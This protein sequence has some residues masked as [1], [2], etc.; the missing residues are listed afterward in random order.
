M[1][2]DKVPNQL[3]EKV[4]PVMEVN[5]RFFR[6]TDFFADGVLTNSTT[7]TIT[8]VSA[9]KDTF[10]TGADISFTKDATATTTYLNLKCYINGVNTTIA[11]FLCTSLT[12]DSQSKYIVFANPIKVDRGTVINV[13]SSTNVANI[14]FKAVVNGYTVED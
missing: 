2:I 4:V 12:A 5:P 1:Q 8:T 3:A 10:I 9:V 11:T 14:S 6:I 13:A 7:G